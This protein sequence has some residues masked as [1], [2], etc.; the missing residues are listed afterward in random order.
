MP[1]NNLIDGFEKRLVNMQSEILAMARKFYPAS[2]DNAQDLAQETM[3]RILTER[4]SYKEENNF[5]G[6]VYTLMSHIFVDDMRREVLG[7]TEPA[8]EL[9]S[10][11]P[12]TPEKQLLSQ[13]LLNAIHTLPEEQQQTLMLFLDGY[14]GKEIAERLNVPEGT[15]KSR[16]HNVRVKMKAG[17]WRRY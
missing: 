16:L 9:E 6:W 7:A 8:S 12:M 17:G 3:L 13:D 5:K 15:V 11:D 1:Q 4:K 10:E 2:S 14:S